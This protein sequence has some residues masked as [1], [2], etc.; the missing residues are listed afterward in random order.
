[1]KYSSLEVGGGVFTKYLNG[2]SRDDRNIEFM[3]GGDENMGVGK[4]AFS[5]KKPNFREILVEI[6][7]AFKFM[8]TIHLT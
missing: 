8:P 5:C 7:G 1:M 2:K 4:A 3:R 6:C